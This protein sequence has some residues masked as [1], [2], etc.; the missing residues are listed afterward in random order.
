[1][2]TKKNRV[3]TGEGGGGCGTRGWRGYGVGGEEWEMAGNK[4]VVHRGTRIRA[5]GRGGGEGG[6]WGWGVLLGLPR[7]DVV[8]ET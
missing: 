6:T 8:L 4:V 5:Y 1:V 3:E 7:V 2:W